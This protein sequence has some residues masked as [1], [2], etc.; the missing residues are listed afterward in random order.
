MIVR[1]QKYLADKGVASRRKCEEYIRAG[2]VKVNGKVV[3]EMGTKVDTES[4]KVEV[5]NNLQIREQQFV[6]F[7]LH[8]PVGYVC[9]VTGPET[10]KIMELLGDIKERVFPVGRLD[11]L[12]SGLLLVTNDGR[13]AYEMTHP[14][15]EKEKEYV[16]KV[17]EKVT[18]ELL[19][20]LVQPF[21]I[22]GRRTQTAKATLQ[23]PHLFRIIL[24]E[25]RNR[26][27]RRMCERVELHIEKLKRVR[28]GPLVLG[29]I[30]PGKFRKLT[31]KEVTDILVTLTRAS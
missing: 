13:F 23:G 1:L 2:F 18:E 5:A 31:N 26:Q 28:V 8:K 6:Y 19:S 29:D 14:K 25:G 15:F 22:H 21:F 4:D 30:S 10:P 24:T 27:I 7:A 17:R 3:T 16:I 12:T 11:K 9:S 20:K